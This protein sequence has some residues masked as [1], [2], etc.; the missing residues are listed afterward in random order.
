[1]PMDDLPGVLDFIRY[2][3]ARGEESTALERLQR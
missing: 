3:L 2:T 1:M